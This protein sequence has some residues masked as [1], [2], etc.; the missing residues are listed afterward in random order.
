VGLLAAVARHQA[1]LHNKFFAIIAMR[2]SSRELES[3]F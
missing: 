3:A 2:I 1:Q